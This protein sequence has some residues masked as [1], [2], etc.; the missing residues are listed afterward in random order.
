MFM[1]EAL[2]IRN[3]GGRVKSGLHALL[4]L[5]EVTKSQALKEVI[6]IHHTSKPL[7]LPNIEYHV[8]YHH[9]NQPL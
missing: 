8:P 7:L 3:L 2:V 4:F 9:N 1:T 5:E 6:I